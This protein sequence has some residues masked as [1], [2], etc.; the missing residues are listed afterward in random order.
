MNNSTFTTQGGI[1]IEKS[2][3]P[4]DAEHALDKIYQYIDTKKGALFVS[5]YEVPDRYSRWDLGF[6]HPALE[7]IARKR[8]FEINALNPNGTRLLKLIAPALPV[9]Y[10][11][12]TLPTNREV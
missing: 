6:V 4:L 1:K 11:H 10:T 9:S 5:N 3:T 12:L 8:Q 2:I 7:L